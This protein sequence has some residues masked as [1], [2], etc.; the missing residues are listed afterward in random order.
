MKKRD[1]AEQQKQLRQDSYHL[2]LANFLLVSRVKTDFL[3]VLLKGSEI[4]TSLREFTFLHTLT[5]VPVDEGTLGVEEIEL[6][7]KPA[8]RGRDG[9]RVGEH[10]QRA[11]NLGKITARDVR[12]GL[13]ANTELEA[14]W[15]PVDELNSTLRLDDRHRGVD[16]LRNDVAT[17]QQSTRHCNGVSIVNY[18]MTI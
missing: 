16:V 4:L 13:V 17:V 6:V 7:V 14:S 10:A 18:D 1:N 8:P 9:G 5:D 3:V 2:V 11:S 12:R 15:A